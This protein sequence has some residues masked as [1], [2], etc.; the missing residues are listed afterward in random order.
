LLFDSRLDL[1]AL[2]LHC[3]KYLHP[4]ANLPMQLGL[5]HQ[6]YHHTLRTP[7]LPPPPTKKKHPPPL[8]TLLLC[9]AFRPAVLV[10][11]RPRLSHC[12]IYRAAY[13]TTYF[14][15]RLVAWVP[16]LVAEPC[17]Q[18]DQT[19]PFHDWTDLRQPCLLGSSLGN[20]QES[21]ETRG[22]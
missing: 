3:T 7:P 19:K 2:L 1:H 21:T 20:R 4:W 12:S 18:L 9:L 14:A 6:Y 22:F 10:P 11:Y 15:K 13:C 5:R 17:R 16:L 8:F